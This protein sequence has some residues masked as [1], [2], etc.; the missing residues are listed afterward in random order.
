MGHEVRPSLGE[1]PLHPSAPEEVGRSAP[2]PSST[3][4]RISA[5]SR[6]NPGFSRI[7]PAA[8]SGAFQHR[9]AFPGLWQ[10]PVRE[11]QPGYKG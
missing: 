2:A 9:R 11:A 6:N 3:S 1:A 10:T 7:H 5:S 8:P 4:S